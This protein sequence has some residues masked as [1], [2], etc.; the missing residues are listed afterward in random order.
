MK[1]PCFKICLLLGDPSA[2]QKQWANG[3]SSNPKTCGVK[4]KSILYD[5]LGDLHVRGARPRFMVRYQLIMF[6][7]RF[8]KI[9]IQGAPQMAVDK[10]AISLSRVYSYYSKCLSHL[11]ASTRRSVPATILSVTCP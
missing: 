6:L 9:A 8:N 11:S 4:I 7:F 5:I 2:M 1:K 10:E 3:V